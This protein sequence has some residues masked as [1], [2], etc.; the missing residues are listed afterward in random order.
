MG[1]SGEYSPYKQSYFHSSKVVAAGEGY[2]NMGHKQ[3]D[4]VDDTSGRYEDEIPAKEF[5]QD[6][7][8]IEGL[9]MRKE[10]D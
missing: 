1:S 10:L 6:E 7:D 8:D 5:G 9:E 4:V 3:P 2:E